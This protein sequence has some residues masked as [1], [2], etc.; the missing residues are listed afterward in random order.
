MIPRFASAGLG[1]FAFAVATLSGLF[2]GNPVDT[3]LS[4]SILALFLFCFIGFL[5]GTV[6]QMVVSEHEKSV[7]ADIQQRFDNMAQEEVVEDDDEEIIEAETVG[8]RPPEPG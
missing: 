8:F 2:A 7:L 5:L 4:R 1:L 3:I 6:T